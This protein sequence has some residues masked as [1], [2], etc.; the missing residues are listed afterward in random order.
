MQMGM[1]ISP[2][3]RCLCSPFR[4]IDRHNPVPERPLQLLF[5][6]SE[7]ET[8]YILRHAMF[9]SQGPVSVDAEYVMLYLA[10]HGD[11]NEIQVSRN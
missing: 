4:H 3:V 7:G 2:S 9:I 11:R 8:L 5:G 10:E 1:F 6:V